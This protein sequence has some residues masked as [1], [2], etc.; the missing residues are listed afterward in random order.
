MDCA[1]GSIR[2]ACPRRVNREFEGSKGQDNRRQIRKIAMLHLITTVFYYHV[3]SA[4]HSM[5]K[6]TFIFNPCSLR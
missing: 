2:G 3:Q 6:I 5:F 4:V 1:G